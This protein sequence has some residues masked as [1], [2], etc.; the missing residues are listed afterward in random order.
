MRSWWW[1][2]SDGGR[3]SSCVSGP[4]ISPIHPAQRYLGGHVDSLH[5]RSGDPQDSTVLWKRKTENFVPF[6]LHLNEGLLMQQ[7]VSK[8]ERPDPEFFG[9][10]QFPPRIPLAK[11]S[12]TIGLT[13]I[14]GI[15]WKD[16]PLDIV[17]RVRRQ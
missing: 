17:N 6:S 9:R 5:G 11:V 13:S 2:R 10:L 3:H 12:E 8:F 16:L 4:L 15:Q 1:P 7:A 14:D